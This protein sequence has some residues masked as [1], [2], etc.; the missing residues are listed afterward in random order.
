MAKTVDHADPQ[1]SLLIDSRSFALRLNDTGVATS[2][3]FELIVQV[4]DIS[5]E[6]SHTPS[7]PTSKHKKSL[8][9][10]FARLCSSFHSWSFTEIDAFNL[11][12]KLLC[13]G[14][15]VVLHLSTAEILNAFDSLPTSK[16]DSASAVTRSNRTR[17][18]NVLSYFSNLN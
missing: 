1:S 9:L 15:Y 4:Y 11:L 12:T 5:L 3:Q 6:I 13:I 10:K 17:I 14:Q 2:I 18:Q 16:V 7:P 8:A